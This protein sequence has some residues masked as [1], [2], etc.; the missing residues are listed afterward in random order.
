MDAAQANRLLAAASR[1]YTDL[2]RNLDIIRAHRGKN[3]VPS[4]GNRV[5]MPL[6]V[7][8]QFLPICPKKEEPTLNVLATAALA[9]WRPAMDVYRFAP[10]VFQALTSTEIDKIPTAVLGRLPAWCLYIEDGGIT[11]DMAG[12]FVMLNDSQAYGMELMIL[13]HVRADDSVLMTHIIPLTEG[14]LEDALKSGLDRFLQETGQGRL[15]KEHIPEEPWQQYKAIISQLLSLILYICSEQPDVSPSD[16][17]Q[18]FPPSIPTEK[19]TKQGW[20]LFQAAK[21]TIWSVGE[22]IARQIQA[23]RELAHGTH[24]GPRPHIRRAHWHGFWSGT[25]KPHEGLEPKPRRFDLRWLP[26]IPVAMADDENNKSD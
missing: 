3:D 11:N 18:S 14:S 4:W 13:M 25:I 9:A 5:F 17:G 15:D 8:G 1:P 22:T 2:W 19:K 12:Y 10:D 26:P 24:A 21:P 16:G 23:G 7:I 6:G 20:R